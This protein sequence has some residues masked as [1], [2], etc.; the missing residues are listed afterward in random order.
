MQGLGLVAHYGGFNADFVSCHPAVAVTD[1]AK[2]N[3]H[4]KNLLKT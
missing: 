4:I 3:G 2:K 1:I